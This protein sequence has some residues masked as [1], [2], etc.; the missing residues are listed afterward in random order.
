[1]RRAALR[2][3]YSTRIRDDGKPPVELEKVVRRLDENTVPMVAFNEQ[4][5]GAA[6]AR[7]ILN[8]ISKTLEG[9]PAAANTAN[10]KRMVLNSA[11]E[12]GQEVGVLTANPFKAVKWTKPRRLTTVDPCSVIN[13]NQARRFLA[14]VEAN[15]NRGRRMKAFFGCMYYAALRPEEV[16]DL[17]REH[18]SSLPE[19]GW[20]EMRLTNAEPR[21]GSRWTNNG[22][23]RERRGLKHRAEGDTRRVPIHPELVALLRAHLKEFGT[24]PDRR[25]LHR[26]PWRADDRSGLPEGLPRG[27]G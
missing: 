27:Q 26:S 9:K 24:G 13:I 3:A 19:A 8:R 1:M 25:C 22:R 6:L 18:L 5:G 4:G 14:E 2:W 23:R 11:M 12:F 20:G 21:S 7:G 10:R 17:R 16:V 15:S